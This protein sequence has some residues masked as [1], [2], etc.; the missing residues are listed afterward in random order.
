MRMSEGV[1]WAL[2][3]ATVLALLPE[4]TTLPAA[5]LAEFHELPPAYLAKVFQQLTRAGIVAA[6][7]GRHGGYRL[8]KPA[9]EITV[10]DIVLAVDGDE[11]AFRC[12]EIRR[13]GPAKV[14]DRHYTPRCGIAATMW[15]A[16]EA[17]RAELAKTTVMDLV[18]TT[19]QQASPKAL[20]KGA[21]WLAGQLRP[22]T[23]PQG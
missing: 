3:C 19:A 12:T 7:P 14:A 9:T 2:H 21:V 11:T 6:T 13:R 8:A 4:G 20:E 5:R 22:G 17:W 1:E 16:E 10:L 23:A 18:V 15:R